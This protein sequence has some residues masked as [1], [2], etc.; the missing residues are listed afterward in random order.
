MQEAADSLG[1]HYRTAWKMARSGELPSERDDSAHGRPHRL[2][3]VDLEAFLE[4]SRVMPGM[5]AY[6]LPHHGE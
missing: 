1:V 6:P 5:V 3:R 4:Q 2:R